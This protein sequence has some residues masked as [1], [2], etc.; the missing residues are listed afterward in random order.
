MFP[1]YNLLCT[2]NNK[3]L[4]LTEKKQLLKNL[5]SLNENE[6][7]VVFAIIRR[8]YLVNM[9][10]DDGLFS[11]PYKG[12]IIANKSASENDIEFDLETLPSKLV[13]M[14]AEFMAINMKE[15]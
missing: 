12:K 10:N 4:T 11:L 13:R 2:N 5:Q 15:K 14:L 1:L 3:V 7:A 6:H 9:V 8:Y